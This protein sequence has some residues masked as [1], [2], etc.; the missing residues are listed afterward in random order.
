MSDL[1]KFGISEN[2]ATSTFQR[3]KS[4]SFLISSH[5]NTGFGIRATRVISLLVVLFP[6]LILSNS[7][8]LLTNRDN[9]LLGK[10]VIFKMLPATGNSWC[11]LRRFWAQRQLQN[12]S[13]FVQTLG[14]IL[15]SVGPLSLVSA[16]TFSF[17]VRFGPVNY[18]T[19][20]IHVLLQMTAKRL[21]NFR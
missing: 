14:E 19:E 16:I 6:V 1:G 15:L 12:G 10:L 5:E 7:R 21:T 20:G 2:V 8:M 11:G 9:Q 3:N 18:Q 17:Q 13:L 4:C